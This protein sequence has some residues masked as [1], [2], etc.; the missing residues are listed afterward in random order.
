M[1]SFEY[2]FTSTFSEQQARGTL[3]LHHLLMVRGLKTHWRYP[4]ELFLPLV[5]QF[6]CL[7]QVLY[8][9][10]FAVRHSAGQRV[11]GGSRFFHEPSQAPQTVVHGCFRS[12]MIFGCSSA[13]FSVRTCF[14]MRVRCFELGGPLAHLLEVSASLHVQP[15]AFVDLPKG[16]I[17]VRP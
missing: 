4:L 12:C 11:S 15:S 8:F 9:V 16:P 17:Q 14:L 1:S 3:P 7:P 2:I 6:V 5:N 10:A 13:T